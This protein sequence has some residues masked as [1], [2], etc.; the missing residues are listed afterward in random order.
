MALARQDFLAG[1]V[2]TNTTFLKLS[3]VQALRQKV[4]CSKQQY[5][6]QIPCSLVPSLPVNLGILDNGLKNTNKIRILNVTSDLHQIQIGGC[7]PVI[8]PDFNLGLQ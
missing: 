5:I 7:F 8:L 6:N 3:Q 4:C 2:Y 1:T